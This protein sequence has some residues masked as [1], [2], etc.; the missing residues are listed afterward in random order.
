MDRDGPFSHMP[1]TVTECEGFICRE[2][3]VKVYIIGKHQVVIEEKLKLALNISCLTIWNTR[4]LLLL[5]SA[6]VVEDSAC[7]IDQ[8]R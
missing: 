7:L 3:S 4:H 1:Q 5:H 2:I 6:L 8:E